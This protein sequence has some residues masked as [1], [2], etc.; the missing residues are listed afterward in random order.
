MSFGDKLRELRETKG[1]TQEELGKIIKQTKSNISKYENN[2]LQ[3]SI[4]VINIFAKFFNT[5]PNH[6]LGQPDAPVSTP[7]DERIKALLRATSDL[8]ENEKDILIEDVTSY[9]EYK[10]E[11]LRRRKNGGANKQ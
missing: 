5:S 10:K 11:Q 4:E 9:L 8:T 6:L 2:K 3:P 7:D 1:L